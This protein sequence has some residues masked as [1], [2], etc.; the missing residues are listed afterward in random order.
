MIPAWY[1]LLAAVV[2]NPAAAVPDIDGVL[3]RPLQPAA[4][5]VSLVVFVTHDCPISNAFA[6][7]IKRICSEY[8]SK[9]VGCALVYVDPNLSD[10]DARTHAAEYGHAD[11]PKIVDRKHVLVGA[12]GATVTPEAVV[13][14]EGGELAYRGRID[15]SFQLLGASRRKVLHP[16][17]R[18]AL[19]DVLAHRPVSVRETKAIGCYIPDLRVLNR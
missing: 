6:P 7:E 17:L 13:I 3:R 19:D 11:Y 10:A 1:L 4:G 8:Q 15:D 12:A 5:R 16:D 9:G 14:R 2:H 18:N